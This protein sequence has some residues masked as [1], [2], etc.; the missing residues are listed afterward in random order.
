VR[1]AAYHA[2]EHRLSTAASKVMREGGGGEPKRW[3]SVGDD[4]GDGDSP[5]MDDWRAALRKQFGA[6]GG[7]EDDGS[8]K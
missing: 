8:G 6:G 7:A 4:E 3:T 5:S 2:L 1:L